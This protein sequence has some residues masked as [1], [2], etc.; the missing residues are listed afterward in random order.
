MVTA[1][2]NGAFREIYCVFK[3][4]DKRPGNMITDFVLFFVCSWGLVGKLQVFFIMTVI[5]LFQYDILSP[6]EK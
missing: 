2:V 3:V 1:S 4:A 5:S 6:A